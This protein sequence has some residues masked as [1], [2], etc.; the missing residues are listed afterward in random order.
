MANSKLLLAAAL[1]VLSANAQQQTQGFA[2]E[3]FYP[4]APGGG[5]FVMDDLNISGGFGG[6]I[7]L[8]GGYAQNPIALLSSQSFIDVGLAA[9]YRRYR[10]YLNLPVP[11][12]VTGTPTVSPGTN[13]DTISDTRVGFDAL[14]F[15]KPGDAVRFGA[16]AQLLIPSGARTDYVSD[17][18][19]RGMFRF[20]AAG[21]ARGFTYAGQLGLHVRPVEGSLPPGGPDGNELLFGIAAGRKLSVRNGWA[22]IVGPEFFGE[23][24]V[25]SFDRQTGFE[26]LMTGRLEG[27]GTGKHMRIKLGVGHGIVQSFGVP[28]WRILAGVELFGRTQ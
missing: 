10:V 4:S 28:E 6:A 20:L 9:T 11:V 22:L 14:L 27:T 19:Y 24:T 17:G 7:S 25:H 1:L 23:T 21:D 3:R 12:A 5:W 8:T 18:R 13:P 2:V 15:G 26:G 16:G